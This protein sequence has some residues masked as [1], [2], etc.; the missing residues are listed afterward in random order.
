MSSTSGS[1][2]PARASSS[3]KAVFPGAFVLSFGDEVVLLVALAD[4]LGCFDFDSGVLAALLSAF[5]RGVFF[6]VL[7][8]LDFMSV[9]FSSAI[10]ALF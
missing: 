5:F 3:A 6:G 8:A 2:D 1:S 7:A 10:D 4:L 9:S